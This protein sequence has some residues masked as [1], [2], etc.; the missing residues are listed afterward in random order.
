MVKFFRF[1]LHL[2]FL[3]EN[4]DMWEILVV[5]LF[6]LILSDNFFG[7]EPRTYTGH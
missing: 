7:H 3:P 2:F 1:R 5:Q 4:V 6:F